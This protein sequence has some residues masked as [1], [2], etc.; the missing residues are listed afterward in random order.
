MAASRDEFEVTAAI[1]RPT[2][3]KSVSLDLQS[4]GGPLTKVGEA[5]K[6]TL[7]GAERARLLDKLVSADSGAV[8]VKDASGAETPIRIVEPQ[9]RVPAAMF[10]A[11]VVALESPPNP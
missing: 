10:R 7:T 9:D 2:I 5:A 3:A 11:C 8:I 6:F 4:L 1:D